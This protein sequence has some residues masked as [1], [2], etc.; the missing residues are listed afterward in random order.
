MDVE[1]VYFACAVGICTVK[2]DV[3]AVASDVKVACHRDC[4]EEGHTLVFRLIHAGAFYG[5]CH[6]DAEV[7]Q[8]NVNNGL[9]GEVFGEN[10]VLDFSGN[11]S[12]CETAYVNCAND[13]EVDITVCIHEIVLGECLV[14]CVACVG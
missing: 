10:S 4:L 9:F 8:T 14:G 13:R 7:H 3:L 2:D 12:F 5:A 11:L 1:T 6:C